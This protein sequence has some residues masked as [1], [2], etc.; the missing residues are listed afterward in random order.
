LV[1]VAGQ[2]M[3]LRSFVVAEVFQKELEAVVV[4]LWRT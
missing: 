1:A 2:V 3:D 4:V